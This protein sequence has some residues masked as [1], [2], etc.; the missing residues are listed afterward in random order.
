M[1]PEI[2]FANEKLQDTFEKLKNSRTEDKKL[3]KWI[4]RAFEDIEKNVF[5]GT[6][7][8]KKLIPKSYSDNFSVDNL[9]K[10]DL[11][12]AWRLIYTVKNDKAFVLSIILEW[13]NHKEYEKRFRY[14]L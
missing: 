5:C 12:N 4:V 6:Q 2:N 13:F 8:S 11:P 1:K 9:W 7:I 14:L 3:Y 10:Y